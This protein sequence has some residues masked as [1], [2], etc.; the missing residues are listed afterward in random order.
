MRRRKISPGVEVW[1]ERETPDE[2]LSQDRTPA[3]TC[4]DPWPQFRPLHVLYTDRQRLFGPHPRRR[5]PLD[6]E[7]SPRRPASTAWVAPFRQREEL[8]EEVAFG[9]DRVGAPPA[10]RTHTPAVKQV[11]DV[12]PLLEG[13]ETGHQHRGPVDVPLP[14]P[15][16]PVQ[17]QVTKEGRS[18]KGPRE[19]VWVAPRPVP[20]SP[21]LRRM[22]RPHPN[23][24]RVW[25]P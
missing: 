24:V 19:R 20:G 22:G 1:K 2:S 4:R 13:V 21:P 7:S 17:T 16:P 14:L 23:P 25:G 6:P 9:Q 10:T 8:P 3:H 11:L 5:T 15:L 12:D 18:R